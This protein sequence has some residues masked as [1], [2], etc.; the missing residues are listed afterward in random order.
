M[1]QIQ[2]QTDTITAEV[3][4]HPIALGKEYEGHITIQGCSLKYRVRMP[5]SVREEI[6]LDISSMEDASIVVNGDAKSALQGIVMQAIAASIKDPARQNDQ[7]Y[8]LDSFIQFAMS[9]QVPMQPALQDLIDELNDSKQDIIV[10]TNRIAQG[11]QASIEP[12]I[13]MMRYYGE[14]ATRAVIHCL[15]KLDIKGVRIHVA[16]RDCCHEDLDE[17][18][19]RVLEE[20]T[21]LTGEVDK[22][23][24]HK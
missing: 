19:K 6:T 15:E 9:V 3:V 1:K 7:E 8:M 16:Y 11:V 13:L 14:T 17:F 4:T 5:Q 20:D 24:P 21:T 23:W 2:E 10:V 12:L 18:S 22:I